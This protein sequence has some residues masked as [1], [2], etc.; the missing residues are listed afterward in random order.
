MGTEKTDRIVLSEIITDPEES[1]NDT[2]QW[3]RQALDS[4]IEQA[5]LRSGACRYS[6]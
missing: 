6:P 1:I 5:S 3:E 4:C 2:F